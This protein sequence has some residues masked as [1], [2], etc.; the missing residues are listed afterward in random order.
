MEAEE[1]L[2]GTIKLKSRHL[3]SKDEVINNVANYLKLLDLTGRSVLTPTPPRSS[4]HAMSRPAAAA[5]EANE[6]VYEVCENILSK[7]QIRRN[8]NNPH[9]KPV[10]LNF[11]FLSNF[12]K[13]QQSDIITAVI[14]LTLKH[15][16]LASLTKIFDTFNYYLF[17]KLLSGV[18][19]KWSDQFET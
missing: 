7:V 19:V 1:L 10:N 16:P 11:G 15:N 6:D 8:V 13:V 17:D 4:E 12:L 2:C 5:A 14:D 18:V 3:E 9:R